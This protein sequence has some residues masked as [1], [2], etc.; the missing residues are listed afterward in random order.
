MIHVHKS[1]FIGGL[2]IVLAAGL[3]WGLSGLESKTAAKN[4]PATESGAMMV[5]ASFSELAKQAQPGVVNIRT[6]KTVEGGGPVF[7]HFFGDPF[8]RKNP[9]KTSDLFLMSV[10]GNSSKEVWGPGS[11]STAKATLSP[12]IM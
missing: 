1:K 8:G 6:V 5:P 3:I 4:T 7:R 9:L 10:N 11:S 12:I 2:V